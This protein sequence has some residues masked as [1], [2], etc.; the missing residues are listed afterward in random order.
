MEYINYLIDYYSFPLLTAFLL[1][2]LTSISPCPLVINITAI[3]YLSKTIK[4]T[5]NTLFNGLFYTLGRMVSYTLLAVAV[6]YGVS[7]FQ[8][9]R[10][11][12]GWGEKLVGPI[13]I[14]I[15]V[16]MLSGIKLGGVG[17]QSKFEGVKHRLAA[18]GYAGSFALGMLLALAFCPYSGA[19]FF[20]ALMPLIF[21]SPEHLLLA[22]IFALGTGIPVLIFALLLAYSLQK[23]G[24]AFLGIQKVEK[25]LRT[26]VAVIFIVAGIYYVRFLLS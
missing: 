15:G 20:G 2:I 4:S 5:K 23:M 6:Y 3:A 14:A 19:L 8:L 26:L 7:A 22:P 11:F 21:S 16:A 9:A 18:Q 24:T 17:L 10:I 13:L 25:V 12:Q 1:G